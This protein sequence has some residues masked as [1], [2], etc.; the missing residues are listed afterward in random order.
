M[1][2][3]IILQTFSNIALPYLFEG[4]NISSASNSLSANC[5]IWFQLYLICLKLKLKPECCILI[6]LKLKPLKIVI[7]TLIYWFSV[8]FNKREGK[9]TGSSHDGKWTPP[10]M[11]MSGYWKIS[12]RVIVQLH[13]QRFFNSVAGLLK[14]P[15][16]WFHKGKSSQSSKSQL[17]ISRHQ[18]GKRE[19][20]LVVMYDGEIERK[21]LIQTAPPNTQ[22]DLSHINSFV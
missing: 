6:C 10:L 11:Y 2:L 7:G 14:M 20:N 17:W 22:F 4:H 12:G 1:H 8:I 5:F 18:Y 3:F 9:R 15:A 13:Y 16:N 21:E 19:M